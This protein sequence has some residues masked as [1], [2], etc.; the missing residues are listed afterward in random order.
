MF[1]FLTA[2]TQHTYFP[3]GV[4]QIT[5]FV[6]WNNTPMIFQ[7]HQPPHQQKM[8]TMT[9]LMGEKRSLRDGQSQPA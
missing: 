5:T 6:S 3:G 9:F 8:V 2:L 4:K 1:V 7:L